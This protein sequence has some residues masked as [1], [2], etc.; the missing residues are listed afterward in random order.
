MAIIR[1][2]RPDVYEHVV[3]EV[4]KSSEEP[5]NALVVINNTAIEIESYVQRPIQHTLPLE[6]T[7]I[8]PYEQQTFVYVG[9]ISE[10]DECD[11]FDEE[12]CVRVNLT[13]YSRETRIKTDFTLF[14]PSLKKREVFKDKEVWDITHLFDLKNDNDFYEGLKEEAKEEGIILPQSLLDAVFGP[15][16]QKLKELYKQIKNSA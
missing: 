8:A 4:L 16:D 3:A 9:R 15:I 6:N 14:P 1:E 12:Y 5:K 11:E 13:K 2:N 10:D 7:I